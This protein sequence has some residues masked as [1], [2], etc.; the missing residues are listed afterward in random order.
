MNQKMLPIRLQWVVGVWL[1]L[2]VVTPPAHAHKASDA[3][4]TLKTQSGAFTAQWDLALRDLEAAIGLDLDDD[5]RITW[6]E[7][8]SRQSAVVSYAFS[9]LQLWS[10]GFRRDL[11]L[12]EF[13]VD[14]HSD[15]AYAVLQFA[16]EGIGRESTVEIE[17]TAFFDIDPQHRGLLR[18]EADGETRTG[19]FSPDRPRQRVGLAESSTAGEFLVFVEEGVRHIWMG[20]DHLLFLL[21]LL[22]PSVLQ[23]APD[24][25]Q[26]ADNFL[27]ASGRIIQIVT[28]FTVAHS[29]TLSLAAL[30]IV[31]LPERLVESTIAGSIVIAA[32][33]NLR[34]FIRSSPWTLAFGFGLIHGFGFA[35]V[36]SGLSLPRS[37]LAWALAGFNLGV[38]IGQIAA[39][40]LVFP[41][42][43]VVRGCWFYQPAA[44]K[45]GSATI[46]LLGCFWMVERTCDFKW[47]VF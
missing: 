34:P 3:Y 35:N 41:M 22:L 15:G 26:R 5:G 7:L 21:A 43:F 11:T 19:V 46:A 33:N 40:A 36:L 27:A 20:F 38:E 9:R 18:F 24:G 28:A 17:Y 12:T 32:C 30:K 1:L 8:K 10:G 4:L 47:L 6:G 37:E 2:S 16:I 45:F 14:H 29:L 25:W 23:R 31:S 13:L 42:A 39:V 44:L